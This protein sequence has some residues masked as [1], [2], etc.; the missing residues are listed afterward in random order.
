MNAGGSILLIWSI[1]ST[2]V[3]MSSF[4]SMR[5][6]RR[7]EWQLNLLIP[8]PPSCQF[9]I[10]LQS[11]LSGWCW[12]LQYY[13]SLLLLSQSNYNAKRSW[14]DHTIKWNPPPP[15][16]TQ[17][18]KALPGNP[19]SW[20]SACN[21]MLTQLD[22]IWKKLKWKTTWI[23]QMEDDLNFFESGRHFHFF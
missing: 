17:T 23:F 13:Y 10:Q 21:L 12:P 11:S 14:G 2:P 16:T 7:A 19:G 4:V 9:S 3:N 15:P 6:Y 8:L 22:E 1:L 18:F 5:K 20:F